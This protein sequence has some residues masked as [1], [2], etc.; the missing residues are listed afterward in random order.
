MSVLLLSVVVVRGKLAKEDEV[1][2]ADEETGGWTTITLDEDMIAELAIGG[3]GTMTDEAAAE[4]VIAPDD[5]DTPPG[6]G[7]STTVTVT[8]TGPT[9]CIAELLSDP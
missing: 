5:E 3:T 1:T 9:L 8:V 4:V 2:E 6:G 7:G